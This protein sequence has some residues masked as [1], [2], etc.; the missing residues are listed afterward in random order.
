MSAHTPIDP[1]RVYVGGHSAGGIFAN[2]LLQRRSDRIAGAIV[3]SGVYSQTAP[4]PFVPLDPT[5]VIVTWG[6]EDD[7]WSGRAGN[8]LVRGFGFAA[9]ASAA[10]R[11]YARAGAA[12]VSCGGDNL[13]HAWLDGLNPWMADLL[14]AH[15]KGAPPLAAL[16]P[17][18]ARPGATC[19]LG[20]VSD[21]PPDALVCPASATPGCQY[22]CQGP[23]QNKRLH[24]GRPGA[25][26][27]KSEAGA[28]P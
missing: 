19:V 1:S 25:R 18:P 8:T 20:P 26:S 17:L 21:T 13:G 23:P 2:H 7:R 10:S 28:C 22:M 14:L 5:T 6:G 9:E 3:A 16:P 12:V 15:P 4:D 27:A 11:A 24:R